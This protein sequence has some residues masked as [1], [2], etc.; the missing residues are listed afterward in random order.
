[1]LPTTELRLATKEDPL[2]V[3]P[4]HPLVPCAVERL[5]K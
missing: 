1:L 2:L 3:V 4:P 5:R